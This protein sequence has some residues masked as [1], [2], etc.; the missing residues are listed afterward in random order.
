MNE[1]WV[2]DNTPII[3][4]N[5]YIGPGA[6]LFGKIH[7][8]N[9]CAIGA[10]AVVNKNVPDNVTVAGIPAKII[11][12]RGSKGLI[13]YGTNVINSKIYKERSKY[14]EL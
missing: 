3:G 7:I 6:K 5:V 14:E 4:D 9:N 12:H 1:D 10:N 13:I 8:G 11:N 2:S